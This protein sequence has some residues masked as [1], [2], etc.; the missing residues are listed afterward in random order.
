MR[1]AIIMERIFKSIEPEEN[2]FRFYSIHIEQS[3]FG[4]FMLTC[5]WGR[6]GTKGQ[7]RVIPFDT[8]EDCVQEFKQI[9]KTRKRHGYEE[10]Q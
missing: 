7:T 4:G 3:L 8:I 6:I 1:K 5:T 9:A 10:F 2:R